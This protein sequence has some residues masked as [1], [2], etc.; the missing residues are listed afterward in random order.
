MTYII[1]FSELQKN[2]ISIAGGK[3]ANLGEMISAGFPVPAG[4]IVTTAAYEA[5]VEAN[6]LRLPIW[7]LALTVSE[8]DPLTNQIAS[9]RI[10]QKILDAPLPKDIVDVIK[11]ANAVIGDA[12]IAVRSSATAEDLPD[13]SFAGQQDTFLNI[14][15]EQALLEAVKKCWASLWTA[16]ALAYRHRQGID[17]DSVSIAVVVQ[18]LVDADASGIMFTANPTSG[19]RNQVVINATWGLGEAIVGGLVMPDTVVV[20]KIN[21]HVDSQIEFRQK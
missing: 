7:E 3:G 6:G 10:M 2:N 9:E 20:D 17:P 14:R 13:A 12:A 21:W 5:F 4:Y 1:S 18:E 15:G 19:N 16:R 11:A 8:D